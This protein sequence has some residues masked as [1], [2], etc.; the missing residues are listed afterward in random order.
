VKR[1]SLALAIT[2]LIAIVASAT[3]SRTALGYG[4][5]GYGGH[6][7]PQYAAPL[8]G[9]TNPYVSPYARAIALVFRAPFRVIG[10]KGFGAIS[11]PKTGIYCLTLGP[12]TQFTGTAPLV[13]VEWGNSL[14]VVLFAQWDQANVD[15]GG[16][17][18]TNVIEVRTYKGDT[19]GVG[20]GYQT[21]VL[22][23]DVAF[24][25]YVP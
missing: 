14:G 1:Y 6:N 16:G 10:S 18:L 17:S 11:N 7:A 2:A 19:A 21:P 15:C 9:T 20:S 24:V 4:L 12:G 23:N 13:S 8:V 25:V 3:L 22:S 5:F